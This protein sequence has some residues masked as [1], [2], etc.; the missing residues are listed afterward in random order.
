MPR[1]PGPL[2][3]TLLHALR[4]HG[5]ETSLESLAAFAAGLIPNLD[6]RPPLGRAPARAQYVATARA[7]AALRHRGLIETRTIGTKKGRILWLPDA[8]GRVL[9][10]W[11]FRHPGKRLLVR[12]TVDSLSPKL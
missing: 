4:R 9:P 7:V 2:Q 1:R 5:R 8:N 11:V 10:A 3:L 12:A 6:A